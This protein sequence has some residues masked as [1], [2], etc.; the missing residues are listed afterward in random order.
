MGWPRKQRRAYSLVA[1][2]SKQDEGLE[3]GLGP[4]RHMVGENCQISPDSLASKLMRDK[5]GPPG[6]HGWV[7]IL[8]RPLCPDFGEGRWPPRRHSTELAFKVGK[9]TSIN[10][11]KDKWS[12]HYRM[13]NLFPEGFRFTVSEV[14]QQP[15]TLAEELREQHQGFLGIL[16]LETMRKCCFNSLQVILLDRK[17][18]ELWPHITNGILFGE[19]YHLWPWPLVY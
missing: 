7:N 4:P 2:K 3:Y 12:S 14:N 6:S 9:G 8:T 13:S 11:W 1:W 18:D 19:N 16:A 5:Y 15:T 17:R 10:F